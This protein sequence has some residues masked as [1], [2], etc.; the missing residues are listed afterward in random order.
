MK[1]SM[2]AV[3]RRD[4]L[5]GLALAVSGASAAAGP[6]DGGDS[7]SAAWRGHTDALAEPA[8][9]LRDG[10]DA[11]AQEALLD[12]QVEDLVV[13]GAGL[14]GLTGAWLF[15]RHAGRPVRVL[16]L[17]ALDE[18]GGHARRNEFVSRSGRRLVAYGGSQS[19]DTPS[20][21]SPA[22]HGVLTDL[23]IDLK[24]FETD[25]YDRGWA[26]RHG[27]LHRGR[28]FSREAWGEDRLVVQKAQAEGEGVT[29][30]RASLATAWLAHTPM[31]DGAKADAVA[32]LMSRPRS[33]LLPGLSRQALRGRLAA[34][35]YRHFLLE[36]WRVHPAVAALHQD[37]TLDSFGVGID[38][39]SA[40]DAWAA[41]LPGFA[42][43]DLGDAVDPLMSPSARLLKA[44]DDDDIYRFPDG[45]AGV[46]RALVRALLPR[47]M[48]GRGMETL[49]DGHMD[50]TELDRPE[51]PVRIRLRASVVGLVH[52]GPLE[53]ARLV[54][55]RYVDAQG[56][57]R[58][59]RA[60]QVLL[61]C[62]HRGLARIAGELAG[63]QRQ[64]LDDQVKVPLVY[65]NV[66]LGNWNAWH[67]AGLRSISA[68]GGFW[69]R[70]ALGH[71]VNM[72]AL[73]APDTPDDAILV[74]L[75]K[76]VVPGDGRDPRT[77]AAAGR[78]QLQ[79]WRFERFESSIV[80]MLQGALG[81]Y[82][83]QAAR[84]IEGIVVNRWSHGY[85]YEYMRPWDAYWPAG[86][87][88][89]ETARRGFGRVVIANS[90][91]G[92]YAYAQS[93]IDQAV[94]A[95]SELLPNVGLS[96][97]ARQPGPEPARMG[98]G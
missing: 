75:S 58:E 14:S 24:R 20:L 81:A 47:G 51:A 27:L 69:Q 40:L 64:A 55:L 90:D 50:M 87:L 16:V 85:A 31:P 65:A 5:N 18:V 36:H 8:H 60:A 22:A 74:Q 21:F 94:R 34:M 71:P 29:T 26:R 2:S 17:D 97:W 41:G 46:A 67:R 10:W 83:F 68:P 77:Q 62:W 76:V 12:A 9:R 37:S 48:P 11:F 79:A 30:S 43:L 91:A 82:G 86:P 80:E 15:S 56:C 39:T 3:T 73:R 54:R 95:V 33:P 70:A 61:A 32:L 98:L 13:V 92:A 49:A 44:G 96:G 59:V 23:G 19:L 53:K 7:W 89:C 57:L 45:N 25:F 38:A 52:D 42:S 72:G 78:A 66:L 28:F 93:A 35:T 4:V 88:P 1:A 84:D 6:R 63:A